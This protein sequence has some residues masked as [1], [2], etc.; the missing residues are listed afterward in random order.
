MP[1]VTV[2]IV[3][4]FTDWLI[5]HVAGIDPATARQ[6]ADVLVNHVLGVGVTLVATGWYW[7]RRPGDVDPAA[8]AASAAP[9]KERD[10]RG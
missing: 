1:F 10:P 8:P 5:S 9:V 3:G 2:L 6:V 7:F 4:W